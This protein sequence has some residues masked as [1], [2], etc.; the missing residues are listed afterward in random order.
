MTNTCEKKEFYY[1]LLVLAIIGLLTFSVLKARV[2]MDE[3][4]PTEI[5]QDSMTYEDYIIKRDSL[6][7]EKITPKES[8]NKE[9]FLKFMEAIIT[10]ESKWNKNA[11]C[12]KERALGWMQVRP[13]LIK[14][15]N[16]ISPIK[17]KLDDR[18]VMLK[19]IK[20]FTLY[21]RM[22]QQNA[23]KH[24]NFKRLSRLWN[25]GPNGHRIP[26]TIGYWK[27]VNKVYKSLEDMSFNELKIFNYLKDRVRVQV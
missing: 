6:V 2:M 18:T 3:D 14:D 9:D 11:F 15:V 7:L 12:K 19:N 8:V 20:L 13:I 10:V 23:L 22:Y 24:N 25:G 17:F 4:N 1:M 26:S 21:S 16:R 5:V 27:R